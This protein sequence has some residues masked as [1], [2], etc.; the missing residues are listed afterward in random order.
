MVE[1]AVV[2]EKTRVEAAVGKKGIIGM[3]PRMSGFAEVFVEFTPTAQG[4]RCSPIRLDEDASPHYMPHLV[5]HR[6]DGTYLGVEF[7]DG[8][9]DPINPGDRTYATVRFMY[10]PEVSY[11][12][13]V[14]GARF[15]IREGGRTVGSGRLTRR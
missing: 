15:D 6:S 7:V 12:R 1:Q 5:V 13:L 2:R 3:R 14:E 11:D 9:I 10:E 8:P 4:G